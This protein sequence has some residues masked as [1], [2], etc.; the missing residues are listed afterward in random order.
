MAECAEAYKTVCEQD[1][2][3]AGCLAWLHGKNDITLDVPNVA[4]GYFKAFEDI[5]LVL[6]GVPEIASTLNFPYDTGVGLTEEFISE[7]VAKNL[8]LAWW[9]Q[10]NAERHPD[11]VTV[12]DTFGVIISKLEGLIT[13]GKYPGLN[14]LGNSPVADPY[15]RKLAEHWAHLDPDM[16]KVENGYY[17]FNL[18]PL[19]SGLGFPNGEV[20]M[21][22]KKLREIY[23]KDPT[24]GLYPDPVC[25]FFLSLLGGYVAEFSQL[26]Y[27]W[28]MTLCTVAVTNQE[29]YRAY[30]LTKPRHFFYTR[31]PNNQW[32][33]GIAFEPVQSSAPNMTEVRMEK[34]TAFPLG[35]LPYKTIGP[36]LKPELTDLGGAVGYLVTTFTAYESDVGNMFAS[37]NDCEDQYKVDNSVSTCDSACEAQCNHKAACDW[38]KDPANEPTWSSWLVTVCQ[39]GFG[40]SAENNCEMC[41]PG[42]AGAGGV[43][44]CK[45]CPEGMF[46]PEAGQGSCIAASK[47]HFVSVTGATQQTKCGP[48]SITSTIGQRTCQPC[49]EGSFQSA[50]A[51]SICNLTGPGEYQDEKGATA[52]KQCVPGTHTDKAGQSSCAACPVGFY[53]TA[54]TV[55][56]SSCIPA[57]VGYY[58]DA[59]A[60]TSQTKCSV[61]ESE[62]TL[63]QGANAPTFCVCSEGYYAEPLSAGG[64]QHHQHHQHQQ[65]KQM[66]CRLCQDGMICP[67]GTVIPGVPE[68]FY[69]LHKDNITVEYPFGYETLVDDKSAVIDPLKWE[70]KIFL[71]ECPP[72]SKSSCIGAP[73]VVVV[74]SDGV[75]DGFDYPDQCGIGHRQ[76]SLVCAAC[77]TGPDEVSGKAIAYYPDQGSCKVCADGDFWPFVVFII[78]GFSVLTSYYYLC[79]SETTRNA[80]ALMTTA[81]AFGI[82]ITS[83][84][85]LSVVGTMTAKFTEPYASVMRLLSVFALD[86]EV[87]RSDCLFPTSSLTRFA[88]RIFIPFVVIAFYEVMYVI[89]FG[90]AVQDGK[91]AWS[92]GLF[93]RFFGPKHDKVGCINTEEELNQFR[94]AADGKAN[95]FRFF[96]WTQD[97]VFNSIGQVFNALFIT[98]VLSTL[99]PF[100]CFNQP[101]ETQIVLAYPDVH[102]SYDDEIYPGLVGV[103]LAGLFLYGL[104][105]A[106]VCIWAVW[107][108][109]KRSQQDSSFLVRF[110][111]LFARFRGDRY[112]WYSAFSSYFAICR[113]L[114]LFMASSIIHL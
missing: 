66:I 72:G 73:A 109:P 13:G 52:A 88:M 15:V 55:A 57:E 32:L 48:G 90:P 51:S 21:L 9:E 112:Y 97:K 31:T 56:M 1:K 20:L 49:E 100:Q 35:Y 104:T 44:M 87:I 22:T 111:F 6:S 24:T 40:A 64:M 81:F 12:G 34:Y 3:S 102:C 46:Q 19:N 45:P 78:A 28:G 103:G 29:G 27:A 58:V 92:L 94:S 93:H 30:L 39:P 96:T 43:E 86:I 8:H 41:A 54:D 63:I 83:L 95:G 113:L 33:K 105:F 85:T 114:D 84:Q 16:Y 68:G 75:A 17:L 11:I 71:Y 59:P 106:S 69:L 25:N 91:H 98:I 14:F 76:S 62:T 10:W 67:V 74:Q 26:Q 108:A 61:D 50:E 70:G 37:Y 82:M 2:N 80:S 23:V 42:T 110:K 60:S 77:Y 47:G 79:N 107:D 89:W 5:E 99:L 38:V 7:G 18:Q 4:L 36:K 101:D 65:H 53:G